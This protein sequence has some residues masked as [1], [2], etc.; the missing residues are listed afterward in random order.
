MWKYMFIFKFTLE[1]TYY[2]ILYVSDVTPL[3]AALEELSNHLM[4][5]F[6]I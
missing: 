1:G 6:R 2:C 5:W 4:D 3:M